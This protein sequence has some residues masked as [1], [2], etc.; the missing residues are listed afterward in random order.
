MVIDTVP[1]QAEG[2]YEDQSDLNQFV[3]DG[4]ANINDSKGC[5][6]EQEA[7]NN[8]EVQKE[9]IKQKKEWGQQEY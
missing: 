2:R 5:A 4:V 9:V 6:K 7:L 1:K 8:T 3:T